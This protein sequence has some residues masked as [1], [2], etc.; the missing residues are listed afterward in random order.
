MTIWKT[1][2][3]ID[4]DK[5]I[6]NLRIE[7]FHYGAWDKNDKHISWTEIHLWYDQ[8][9]EYCPCGWEYRSYEGECDSCGCCMSKTPG[10]FDTPTWKCMLPDW[11]K[12]ILA[13][14][15]GII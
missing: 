11:I 5:H 2:K 13:K 14:R 6:G 8:D 15:K 10:D 9:C 3:R 7:S 4:V 12:R 1:K